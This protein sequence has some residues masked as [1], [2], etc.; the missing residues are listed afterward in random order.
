M[1]VHRAYNKSFVDGDFFYKC[2]KEERLADESSYY[3]QLPLQLLP[4]FPKKFKYTNPYTHYVL[5]LQNVPGH[6]LGEEFLNG[7]P[8]K[9]WERRCEQIQG[10]LDQLHSCKVTHHPQAAAFYSS[11]DGHTLQRMY[12]NKTSTEY[13]KLVSKNK[14]VFELWE[15]AGEVQVNGRWLQTFPQVWRKLEDTKLLRNLIYPYAANYQPTIIHGDFC[16]SNMLISDEADRLYLVDPRGSFGQRGVWGDPRYDYAKLKHSY[17]GFYEAI[18]N[19][20][21]EITH[22][23]DYVDY[24]ILSNDQTITNRLF[25]QDFFKDRMTDEITLIEG[26]IFVGMCARHYD[27][28]DRQIVM[29]LTGLER[30]NSL[31]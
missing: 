25:C 1:A 26:L 12:Q 28:L 27:S 8:A 24:S 29:Y 9:Q 19:D 22:D 10:A 18:I 6:N 3:D 31:I 17:D 14:E 16:F 23:S 5:L 13:N 15:E 7:S 30:L 11:E 20:S 21:F 4:L 2:S